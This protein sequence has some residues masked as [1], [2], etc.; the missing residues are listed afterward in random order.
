MKRILIIITLTA[1]C[2]ASTFLIP[3]VKSHEN[4]PMIHEEYIPTQE[5]I[6]TAMT[7]RMIMMLLYGAG[8]EPS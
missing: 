2:V 8:G 4:Y 3:P 6:D 1:L 5:T 7:V